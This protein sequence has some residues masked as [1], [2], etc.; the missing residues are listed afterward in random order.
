MNISKTRNK[1]I[2][3]VGLIVFGI[4]YII[5]DSEVFSHVRV[6]ESVFWASIVF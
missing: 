2:K 5:V 3:T 6:L 1:R 4:S